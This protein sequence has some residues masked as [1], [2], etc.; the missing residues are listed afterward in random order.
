SR[1]EIASANAATRPEGKL[2]PA[3]YGLC[4][5]NQRGE[6]PE[7]LHFARRNVQIPGPAKRVRSWSNLEDGVQIPRRAARPARRQDRRA[8]RNGTHYRSWTA[9]L[10]PG[11]LSSCWSRSR[12]R[13]RV[14]ITVPMGISVMDAISL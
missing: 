3:G 10:V 5:Q 11:W 2:C 6:A 4:F 14:D 7:V 9:S 12:A 13:A 1:R 8:R